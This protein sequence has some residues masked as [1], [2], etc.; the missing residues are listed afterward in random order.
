MKD[1]DREVRREAIR[2]LGAIGPD[3]MAA[4]EPLQ[5]ALADEDAMLSS[6]A[7]SA[8]KKILPNGGKP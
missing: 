7:R 2:A 3:A 5:N 1:K 6:E 4:V 8:L